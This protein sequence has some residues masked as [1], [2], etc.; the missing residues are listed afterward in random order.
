MS[1]F[2]ITCRF[3]GGGGGT[4]AGQ[5]GPA[6]VAIAP[7]RF[8]VPI[9]GGSRRVAGGVRQGAFGWTNTGTIRVEPRR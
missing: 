3:P 2:T 7:G 6:I 9:E 4:V 1:T 8:T 5:P